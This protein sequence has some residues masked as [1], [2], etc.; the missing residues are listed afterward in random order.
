MLGNW[1][2]ATD[3]NKP[4]SFALRAG[5]VVLSTVAALAA[6]E[7]VLRHWLHAVPQLEMDIYRRDAAG[8]LLLRPGIERRHVTRLWDATVRINSEGWR[9]SEPKPGDTAPVVLGLGDSMAFGWGVELEESFL[10]L[11]EE[12]IRRE[13][14]VR[15]V[16]AGV[17][18]TGPSDQLRLLAMIWPRYEPR[19]VLLSFFVGN[20][21]VDVQLGGAAQ[22]DVEDGLLAHRPLGD[23]SSSWL[24]AA[25]AQ[26]VRRSHLLQLLRAVQL[27]WIRPDAPQQ[28]SQDHPPLR[29]D[30]WLREFAQIHR[31]EYPQRTQRAVEETLRC[32]DEIQELCRSRGVPLILVVIP[33][34][35]QVYPEERKEMLGGLGLS[36]DELDL[37]RPQRLLLGWAAERGVT[38]VDLLPAFREHRREHPGSTLYYY[39]DA[40]L[41]ALGH[42]VAAEAICADDGV[43]AAIRSALGGAAEE[44]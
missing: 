16:K 19:A 3:V 21:F 24:A 30:E 5:V 34:G 43:M 9:D 32:L 10:S 37:D 15:L 42:S 22:Y 18:G 31:K 39:P 33:R 27:N 26:L 35:Y 23:E 2:E 13:Q 28:A 44:R 38:A 41:N 6:A 12:R 40:H 29:W 17:P 36:E 8:N 1:Q 4:R 7:F 20:D 11:I 14:P 25:R